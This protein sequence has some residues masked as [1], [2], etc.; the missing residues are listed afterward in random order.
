M[1]HHQKQ[2]LEAVHNK[3]LKALLN[4][5]LKSCSIE[6]QDL[7]LVIDKLYAFHQLNEKDNIKFLSK[8]IDQAFG[9]DRGF[10]IK[11]DHAQMHEREKGVPH[12][13]HYSFY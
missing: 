3:D 8:A 12:T 2:L 13:V 6:G 7:T 10:M 9:G 11:L 5:H 1:E 4:E